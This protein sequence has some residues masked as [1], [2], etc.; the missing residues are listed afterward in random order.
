MGAALV[1]KIVPEGILIPSPKREIRRTP[2]IEEIYPYYASFPQSFVEN[3]LR[4]LELDN[5][6][7]IFDPWN[8]SGTTTASASQQGLASIGFDINPVMV[9]VA[10]ARLLGSTEASS[11]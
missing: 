3:I 11:L 2:G 8:G 5:D 7:T 1:R 9:V 6:A 10:K 4:Q